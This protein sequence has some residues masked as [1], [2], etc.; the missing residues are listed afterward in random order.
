VNT[1]VK[2]EAW[3]LTDWQIEV[4]RAVVIPETWRMYEEL[5]YATPPFVR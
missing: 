5:G 1:H 4:V 2:R 3:A